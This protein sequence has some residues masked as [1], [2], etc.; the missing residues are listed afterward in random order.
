M[1]GSAPSETHCIIIQPGDEFAFPNI[2]TSQSEIIF[3]AKG[4]DVEEY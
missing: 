2:F 4:I 1:P 3:V